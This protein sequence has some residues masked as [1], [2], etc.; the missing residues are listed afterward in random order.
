M[1]I[2]ATQSSS[3]RGLTSPA[4]TSAVAG[5]FSQ[6]LW[7]AADSLAPSAAS[8]V[9][10]TTGSSPAAPAAGQADIVSGQLGIVLDHGTPS[11]VVYF[12]ADG[13]AL[14]RSNFDVTAIVTKMD[15]LGIPSSDLNGLADQ[16][17]A[18]GIGYKPY[19]LYPGTKSDAGV[20]LRDLANGGLGTPYDWRVDPTQAPS[21]EN[22]QVNSLLIAQQL[23]SIPTD[24]G[25]AIDQTAATAAA[26]AVAALADAD[27]Q[28]AASVRLAA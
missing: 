9:A 26:Q 10:P 6:S 7:A 24:I 19:Q 20:D 25:Q 2:S 23:G 21:A 11:S 4:P 13:Q 22:N 1:D 14:T 8:D 5:G 17:D 15:Q 27:P 3:N 18:K 12:D 16:L 28:A